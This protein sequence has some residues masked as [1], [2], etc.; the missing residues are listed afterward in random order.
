MR[1][2][3]LPTR[4]ELTIPSL[5]LDWMDRFL[6]RLGRLVSPCA[7]FRTV[8]EEATEGI[9]VHEP[10]TGEMVAVNQRACE[11]FGYDR[12]EAKD[13]TVGDL[14]AGEPPYGGD[15]AAQVTEKV[16]HEG[17]QT[18]EWKYQRGDGSS[19]WG[20]VNLQT[21]R[22]RG[23][24]RILALVSDITDRKRYEQ[25]LEEAEQSAKRANRFKSAILT[26]LSHAVRTPL[27]IIH[28]YADVLEDAVE[29]E[30]RRFAAHI[31]ESS[32]HLQETYSGLLELAELEASTRELA[33]ERVDLAA[34]AG[35][36]VQRHQSR[37]ETEGIDLTFASP[38]TACVGPFDRA[39]VARI[40]EEFVE[41]ALTFS[42]AGDE[43]QVAVTNENGEGQIEVA[44]TGVGIPEAVQSRVFEAF[45]QHET[46]QE[47]SDRGA[48]IGLTIVQGLVD[49]MGGT[50]EV[51]SKPGQ[52]TKMTVQLPM[53]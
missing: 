31:R 48:G 27:T 28:G 46:P 51:D 42:A 1:S 50:I 30:A 23:G 32:E 15:R 43:V 10:D 13:L 9:M 4:E 47:T 35:M 14:I 22:F 6:R 2:A 21:I 18:V 41:N 39:A 25:A 11:M 7:S 29:G 3:T 16:L 8:F 33:R 12:D 20:E 26:N 45:F 38:E 5:T 53:E 40:F 36:V 44:D 37:A 24:R 19:F 49:L 34:V 17:P 52:G